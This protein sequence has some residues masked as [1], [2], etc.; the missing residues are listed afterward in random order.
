M[1]P[2]YNESINIEKIIDE[3]LALESSQKIEII[4]FNDDSPDGT[5]DLARAKTQQEQRIK[6]MNSACIKPFNIGNPDE[7]TMLQLAD[8]IRQKNKSVTADHSQRLASRRP[9]AEA[10][11]Y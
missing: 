10:A 2:S 11:D 6:L 7:F 3:L 9:H 1:L 5:S 8:L 4:V